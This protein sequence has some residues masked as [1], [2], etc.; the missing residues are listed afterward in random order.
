M[1]LTDRKFQLVIYSLLNQ[2]RKIERGIPQ[3]WPVSPI[4][5]LIYINRVFDQVQNE[6]LEVLSLSFM[7]DLG[8]MVAG[9]SVK[10]IAKILEKVS[11]VVLQWNKDDAVTYDT[12]K[13]EL[14]LFS[15]AWP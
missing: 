6:L 8:F 4:L 1:F 15:K 14:V 2:E 3:R 11:K 13:T 5:F 7:D 9:P 12:G 10:E